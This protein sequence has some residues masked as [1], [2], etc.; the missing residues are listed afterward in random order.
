MRFETNGL[1]QGVNREVQMPEAMAVAVAV[2]ARWRLVV[3]ILLMEPNQSLPPSL[4]RP[5]LPPREFDRVKTL[6][7]NFVN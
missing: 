6:D 7:V 4:P 5:P 2:R 1:S 3:G